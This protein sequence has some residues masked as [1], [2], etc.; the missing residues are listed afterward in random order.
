MRVVF[1]TIY[2]SLVLGEVKHNFISF[3]VKNY[4]NFLRLIYPLMCLYLTVSF[5]F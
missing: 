2:F 3:F 1:K 4:S 5:M